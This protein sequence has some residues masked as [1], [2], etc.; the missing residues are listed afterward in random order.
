MFIT[1][2]GSEPVR[3]YFSSSKTIDLLEIKK[4]IE[5]QI[6]TNVL[7]PLLLAQR[8]RM[9]S[10]Y[11]NLFTDVAKTVQESVKVAADQL[12]DSMKGQFSKKVVTVIK[13]NSEKY[14]EI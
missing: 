5:K 12:D 4:T 13:E 6:I 9:Q 3:T 7:A 10:T 11:D 14:K 2:S 1:E 8:D